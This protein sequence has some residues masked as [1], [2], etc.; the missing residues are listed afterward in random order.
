MI[1]PT[2]LFDTYAL[3]EIFNK[4]SKYERYI[5]DRVIINEFIFAEYCYK[6][7]LENID[8]IDEYLQEMILGIIRPSNEIIK[9]AMIF[10][11]LNK[12]KNMSMTDCISYIQARELGIKFLTGDKEFEDLDNVE[13]VKK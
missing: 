4:N 10:R 2:F 12:K 11:A 8:N 6:L 5:N 3:I 13:F 1:E 7:L 9:K